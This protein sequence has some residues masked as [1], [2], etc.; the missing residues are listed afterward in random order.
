MSLKKDN[1]SKG[2]LL[3]DRENKRKQLFVL[4]SA[5]KPFWRNKIFFLKR[6]ILKLRIFQI[7]QN[8]LNS[9]RLALALILIFA[10]TISFGVQATFADETA[11]DNATV[12]NNIEEVILESVITVI[13]T[14]ITTNIDDGNGTVIVSQNEENPS[15]DIDN[16]T[17]GAPNEEIPLQIVEDDNSTVVLLSQSSEQNNQ[18]EQPAQTEQTDD[19]AAE[20]DS[21]VDNADITVI[22]TGI[23][24]NIDN[25]NGTVVVSQNEEAP[26]PIA[27]DDDSTMI[28]IESDVADNSTGGRIQLPVSDANATAESV[29]AL[30]DDNATAASVIVLAGDNA[31]DSANSTLAAIKIK[32]EPADIRKIGFKN[33]RAFFYENETPLFQ[34]LKIQSAGIF[35]K[36]RMLFQPRMNINELSL[37]GPDGQD[38]AG[39]VILAE[40]ISGY[41]V[42]IEK[43]ADFQP[44][45]YS[46][47]VGYES[48][49]Q[50]YLAQA[51]FEWAIRETNQPMEQSNV[52][53]ATKFSFALEKKTIE[54]KKMLSWHTKKDNSNDP[55][56]NKDIEVSVSAKGNGDSLRLQGSCAKKYFVVLVYPH[57]ND[58]MNDPTMFVYNKGAL[59]ENGSYDYTLNDMPDS[60][61]NG[62]YYLLVGEMGQTG[63]WTPITAIQP[64][65]VE[66]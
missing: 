10:L 19:S 29:I 2:R 38:L 65:F 6:S 44:G 9:F 61:A 21:T 11:A 51:D 4:L 8:K 46:L 23:T 63:S 48:A 26:A 43:P 17:G 45:A 58:Y 28:S 24:T 32:D 33:A 53:K 20:S 47:K 62:T 35:Q 30:A 66:K 16:S 41:Q 40:Q 37:A 64:I 31:T 34:L 49:G 22:D 42:K 7:K 14:G 15:S 27:G 39:S 55:G 5:I 18:T 3:L 25:G 50:D 56:E 57:P 13:D 52:S 60:L 54:T 1:I 12:E 36:I 59:C